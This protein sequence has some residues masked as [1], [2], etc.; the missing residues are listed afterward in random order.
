MA[1]ITGE[2]NKMARK[3]REVKWNET[4]SIT[5]GALRYVYVFSI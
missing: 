3:K 2:E 4:K 5:C 1:N